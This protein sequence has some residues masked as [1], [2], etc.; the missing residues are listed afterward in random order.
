MILFYYFYSDDVGDVRWQLLLLSSVLQVRTRHPSNCYVCGLMQCTVTSKI[1]YI[2]IFCL[3]VRAYRVTVNPSVHL[4]KLQISENVPVW[5]CIWTVVNRLICSVM[6]HRSSSEAQYK[7]ISYYYCYRCDTFWFYFV[8]RHL[9]SIKP[10]KITEQL[11]F[12]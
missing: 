10:L 9:A 6:R 4:F 7:C 2:V 12:S 11:Y 3:V 5:V 8:I 1:Q